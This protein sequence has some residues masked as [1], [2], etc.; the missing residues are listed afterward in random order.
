MPKTIITR[1]KEMNTT[2][3]SPLGTKKESLH[4]TNKKT[5]TGVGGLFTPKSI[6]RKGNEK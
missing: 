5:A 6:T 4:V 1:R 3:G 2:K